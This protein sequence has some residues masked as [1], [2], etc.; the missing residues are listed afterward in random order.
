ME[1]T[2]TQFQWWQDGAGG[3]DGS[4]TQV[5]SCGVVVAVNTL[6]ILITLR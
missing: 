6:S 1:G 4:V 2:Q 5:D 3:P